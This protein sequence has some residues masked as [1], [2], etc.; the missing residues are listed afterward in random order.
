MAKFGLDQIQRICRRQNK[1]DSKIEIVLGRIENIVG[2]GENAGNQHFLLFSQCFQK[3]SFTVSLK[4]V[5]Y[6]TGLRWILSMYNEPKVIARSRLF[7]IRI[8]QKGADAVNL[9]SDC[10]SLQNDLDL[11][12]L[13][14]ATEMIFT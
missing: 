5:M 7:K 9:R 10:V 11:Q 12:C 2:K 8:S 13:Q 6:G 4:V 1:C 3:V 14:N